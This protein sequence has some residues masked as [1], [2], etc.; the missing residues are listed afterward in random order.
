MPTLSCWNLDGTLNWGYE[1]STDYIYDMS[2]SPDETYLVL[3]DETNGYLLKVSIPGL[4]LKSYTT[5]FQYAYRVYISPSSSLI[6]ATGGGFN[7]F[8]LLD[9]SFNVIQGTFSLGLYAYQSYFISNTEY[10]LLVC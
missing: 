4:T 1:L 3:A 7:S 2:L 8:L 10:I 6:L 9:T 5:G